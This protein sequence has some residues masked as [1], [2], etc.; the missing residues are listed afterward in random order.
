MDRVRKLN[1]SEI[2]FV[3]QALQR[4]LIFTV[5]KCVKSSEG[6]AIPLNE[7]GRNY[8]FESRMYECKEVGDTG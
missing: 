5:Y 6:T 2:Y 1:I 7:P 3:Y 8:A 4:K